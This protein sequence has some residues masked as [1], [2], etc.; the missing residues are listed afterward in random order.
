MRWKL[1][2]DEAREISSALARGE[3]RDLAILLEAVEI[4]KSLLPS[5]RAE[6]TANVGAG[7]G[8]ELPSYA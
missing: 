8:H 2:D 4:K 3:N 5:Q 6:G 7:R 1:L